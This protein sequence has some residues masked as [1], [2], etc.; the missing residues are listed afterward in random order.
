MTVNVY[1]Y[2]ENKL[3]FDQAVKDMPKPRRRPRGPSWARRKFQ[4]LSLRF[5]KFVAAL[6]GEPLAADDL[7]ALLVGR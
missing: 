4:S 2:Y 6:K 7:E 3:A 1:T 5:G